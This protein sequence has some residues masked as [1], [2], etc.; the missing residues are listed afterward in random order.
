MIITGITKKNDK[1]DHFGLPSKD[2]SFQPAT[3]A[4][5]RRILIR[6]H[7][8]IRTKSDINDVKER[9]EKKKTKKKK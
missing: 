1:P 3:F 4:I 6:T 8:V 2:I 9:K 5:K 7:A